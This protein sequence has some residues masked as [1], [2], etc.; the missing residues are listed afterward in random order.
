M[1]ANLEK[2]AVAPELGK[3]K[4]KKTKSHFIAITKKGNTKE[5]ANYCTIALILHASNVML[6]ILQ[7][8]IAQYM[9][10]EHPDV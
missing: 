9:N 7:A 5:C 6:K 3:K 8:R 4:K 10:Q 1:L 2:S